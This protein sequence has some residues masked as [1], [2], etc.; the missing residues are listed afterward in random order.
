MSELAPPLQDRVRTDQRT[1]AVP[2]RPVQE[3]RHRRDL[4]EVGVKL[5]VDH[6]GGV[7]V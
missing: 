2:I 7:F 1:S 6:E 5:P 3:V 4:Q